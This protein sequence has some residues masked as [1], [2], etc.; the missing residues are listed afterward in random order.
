[1]NPTVTHLPA[2]PLPITPVHTATFWERGIPS[3]PASGLGYFPHS[4]TLWGKGFSRATARIVST[5]PSTSAGS[6]PRTPYLGDP[7]VESDITG[8]EKSSP[9]GSARS[10]GRCPEGTEG[11]LQTTPQLVKPAPSGFASL[12]HLPQNATVWTGVIGSG[13]AGRWVTV[14]FIVSG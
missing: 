3:D 14:G 2:Q 7:E 8:V 6:C 10:G 11:G 1:M 13:C 9:T 5:K 12:T 4:A